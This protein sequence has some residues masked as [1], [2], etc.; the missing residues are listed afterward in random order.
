MTQTLSFTPERSSYSAQPGYP[1]IEISM[2]GGVSR[3]RQDYLFPP[4]ILNVTWVLVTAAEYSQFMG[5]FRTTIFNGSDAFLMD[6][7][8]DIGE[9]TTHKCRTLGGLPKL[10]QN[11]GPS[12]TVTCTIEAEANPTYTGVITYQEPGTVVF[13]TV[14]PRLVGP[15]VTGDTIRI[16][17][18]AGTHPTGPTALNLDG[19]YVVSGTVGFNSLDLTSPAAVNAGWTTLATLGAPGIYDD[20]IST[21]TRVPT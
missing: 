12:Y 18:S 7:L 5:F 16:L 17:H 3:K 8:T 13:S 4:H 15:I 9:L 19:V 2:D 11:R 1:T 6:L 21:I 20:V 10:I 14:N